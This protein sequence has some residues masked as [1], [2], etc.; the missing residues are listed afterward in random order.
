MSHS[1]HSPAFYDDLFV[2]Y[3][4]GDTDPAAAA[5]TIVR[6]AMP[7]NSSSKPFQSAPKIGLY[8]R[9]EKEKGIG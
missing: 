2:E 3:M 5:A 4:F 7:A 1:A 8:V 6:H 9:K